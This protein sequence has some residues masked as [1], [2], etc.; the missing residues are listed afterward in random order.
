MACRIH[1]LA[2]DAQRKNTVKVKHKQIN[3][4]IGKLYDRFDCII[5]KCSSILM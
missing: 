5:R 2:K 3:T 1:K 4:D